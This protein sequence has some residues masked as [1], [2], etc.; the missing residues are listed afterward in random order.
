[1]AKKQNKSKKTPRKKVKKKVEFN[2]SVGEE[3]T[4]TVDSYD[5]E[6]VYTVPAS[7]DVMAL[8][9]AVAMGGELGTAMVEF[10][11]KYIKSWNMECDPDIKSI[12]AIND[13]G[14]ISDMYDVIT[15][16]IVEAKNCSPRSLSITGRAIS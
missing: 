9:Q 11:A 1:M 14:L 5:I 7:I 16:G 3:K 4:G 10:I 13:A 2:F 15:G 12:R 6:F 8:G